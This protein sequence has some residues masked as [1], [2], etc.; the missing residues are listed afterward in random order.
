MLIR[1]PGGKGRWTATEQLPGPILPSK[2]S[3]LGRAGPLATALRITGPLRRAGGWPAREGHTDGPSEVTLEDQ[4][5][6][7]TQV[8]RDGASASA[9]APAV[10][11][12]PG[13]KGRQHRSRCG[14]SRGH[15]TFEYLDRTEKINLHAFLEARVSIL[16]KSVPVAAP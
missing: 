2:R 10:R 4:R 6:L 5:P 14:H 13:L 1:V 3:D 8:G 11:E 12:Q 16:V 15:I 7:Y 9:P